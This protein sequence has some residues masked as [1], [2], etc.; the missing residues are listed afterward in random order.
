[1]PRR[2]FDVL[3]FGATGYTGEHV[4]R[5]ASEMAAPG[6]SWAGARWAIAGR[7]K[8]KLD[9]IVARHGLAPM[10]VVVADLK[11]ASSMVAMCAR[12]AV[13]MNATGPYRFFGEQVVTACIEAKTDY[14]DLCGEPEFI[15]RCLLKHAD[16]AKAAGVLIVHSCAFDSVPADI[17][18]LFTVRAALA[19]PPCACRVAP[20]RPPG[21]VHAIERVRVPPAP[22]PSPHSAGAPDPAARPLRPRRH[23]PLVFCGWCG[24]G[25]GRSRHDVLRG[26]PWLRRR[27]GDA[28]AA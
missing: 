4:A 13:V 11:D 24:L 19:W 5:A 15:D 28:G 8:A 16:S 3:I 7:S 18:T 27:G 20:W 22:C 25:G 17:G 6:G 21:R 14:V 10:G 23:V 2:E 9:D 26:G 1:M 12:A